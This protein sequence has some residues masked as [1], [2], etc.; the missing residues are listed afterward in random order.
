MNDLERIDK[1]L[2][3][4]NES[5]DLLARYAQLDWSTESKERT[6][7]DKLVDARDEVR[8]LRAR[9]VSGAASL[10]D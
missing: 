1:I 10:T 6:A 3:L 9:L 2:R 4:L 8:T 5:L 7:F